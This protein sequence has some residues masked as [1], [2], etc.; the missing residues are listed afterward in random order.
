[1]SYLKSLLAV[2][3]VAIA[4]CVPAQAINIVYSGTSQTADQAIISLIEGS[5][6]DV[7]I[8]YGDFSNYAT[9]AAVIE[10]ADLFI[11]GRRLTSSAYADATSAGSFNAL[12]VP[13]V[14]F[15]SYVTR[16]DSDRWGWHGGPAIADLSVVGN[17]TT[18]TSA[19]AAAFGLASGD[20][21]WYPEPD[22]FN[23]AG[24]GS[25]G[26]GDILATIGGNILAAHWD[27]GEL[28]GS[29]V[30]FGS[31]RLLFNLSEVGSVTTLPNSAGQQALV[32]AL[33]AFTP[34]MPLSANQWDVDGGGSFNL[35]GNWSSNTVPTQDPLFGVAL[36]AANAPA[37]VT[38]DSPL[39]LNSVTFQ[40]PSQYI[41]AGPEALTLAG[42]HE[43]SVGSGVHTISANVAGTAGLVKSGAGTLLL[44]GAK[45]YTGNTAIQGGTL[46]INNLE[47][48]DN[49]TSSVV[50]LETE[51]ATFAVSA[52]ATGTLAAAL[53][54]IGRIQLDN[55]LED[56][57]TV[58]INRA[59]ASY[60]GQAVVNGGKLA[61]GNSAALGIGGESFNSTLVDG[62]EASGS[63]ALTGG[64]NISSE[65]LVL[66]GRENAAFDA[67]HLTSSGNNSWNG[68]IIGDVGGTQ[69]NIESTSGTLALGGVI[70][71]PDSSDREIVFSGGG[72][73]SVAMISDG[74]R[75]VDGVVTGPSS[76]DTIT[77]VKRGSG[78][79]TITTGTDSVQDYWLGGTVVEQGVLAVAAGSGDAGELQ[80]RSI[81]VSSGATLNVSSFSQY[82]QQVAQVFRGAGTINVGS[83]TLQ[84]FDDASLAPG[85]GPGQ[86]GTLNV[87][88]NATLSS[89][90][91]PGSEG[92][93]SF[94][95]GNSSNPGN[96]QL[97]VSGSF[98]ASGSPAL[99]VNV[100]PAHGHIDAGSHMV[101]SHSGGAV[102]AVNGMAV[103]IT[104]ALGA[105]LTTRQSVSVNG[106]SAGQVNVVVAGEEATR[107]WNGG[108]SGVWDIAAMNNWQEGDQQYR[109]LDRLT[110]DDT[111]SGTTSI[112]VDGP[113][114]AGS[115]T[116]SN[117]SNEYTFA[118]A[119]GIVGTGDVSVVGAGRV[120]LANTGNSY[121]GA[122]TVGS[123]GS[124][125]FASS[126][127]TG[128]IAISGVL[129]VGSI[130]ENLSPAGIINGDF[131]ADP[132][133]TAPPTG[134]TDLST[135]TSFWVGV[136]DEPG[137]ATADEA[138]LAGFSGNFL[139]TAR[140]SAGVEAQPTEGSLVQT[141]DLSSFATDIDDGDQQLFI[142]FD[143]GSDDSRDT[144]IFSMKFFSTTD[145]SGAELGAGVSVALDDDNG[146]AFVSSP[147]LV[148]GLVPIGARSVSIQIDTLRTGGSETN[149]WI[150]NLAGTIGEGF[151][152][153]ADLRVEGDLSMVAG[154]TLELIVASADSFSA[155]VVEG[156]LTADG[157]L[158]LSELPGSAFNLGDVLDVLDFGAVSGEFDNITLP[159]LTSGLSWD[160]SNLLV[161]GELAVVAIGLPGDFNG[162]GVVNAAD[163]TVWRDNQGAGDEES[164]NGNGDGM[165]GVDQA[166]YLVWRNN[167][168]ATSIVGA[169]SQAVP[170]PTALI[171]LAIG[172]GA[173]LRKRDR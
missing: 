29:G 95:L 163:Y 89:F 54:G 48:I 156:L 126:A 39:S 2:M 92:A 7:N 153:T 27:A 128:D 23:A 169:G 20:F 155:A 67:V 37:T 119:G 66:E 43:V 91:T 86:V 146:F 147:E 152:A 41:L 98:T 161:T 150:D 57:D 116:F 165:N 111:A 81:A 103:Q 33:E 154:S 75:D 68:N 78:T 8:N 14:A 12:T 85:D 32:N 72:N 73:F 102:T 53:T 87:T 74:T 13:V 70:S 97:A 56:A 4:F 130:G 18:V 106:S 17:E 58:T 127:S 83:G 123:G 34:L 62:G 121:T 9:N 118:G 15:T 26:E 160:T 137:N 59:N 22:M 120:T 132:D 50:N 71:T 21:D 30:A 145:G 158:L 47:S 140:L 104:D 107:T 46:R 16:P 10:N 143:W 101:L 166:D 45:S 82:A 38:L 148:G 3:L 31:D 28:S 139:T 84:L 63:V 142:D 114:F 149:L 136:A 173:A 88:G 5:F 157:T 96:D 125:R 133:N 144:G 93:W 64:V 94:D 138:A 65:V 108:V 25:V 115:V 49:Q 76:D 159:D 134:W 100:T 109:D 80:S 135:E 170:E 11:V 112:V 36:T 99:A 171:L 24:S 168:G 90:A 77:V 141:I 122:T 52:G 19:G 42:D 131:E 167:Y 124:L 44:E 55:D 40:N 162:D 164:L 61:V 172:A 6:D 69:Y 1:M 117:S 35:S 79:L 110:F 151:N 51:D 113:R 60:D 105:P 129:T